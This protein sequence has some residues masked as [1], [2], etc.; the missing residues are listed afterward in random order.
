MKRVED[1][2]LVAV[3]A[4]ASACL[5]GCGD[6]RGQAQ[7][8]GDWQASA[9]AA[10]VCADSDGRRVIDEHCPAPGAQGGGGAHWVYFPR[11]AN[12]P[13]IGSPARAGATAPDGV[14]EYHPAP[15]E[16]ISRG[17]FGGTAGEGGHGEGG[18]GGGGEGGAGE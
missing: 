13:A 4:A 17:G 3:L 15:V 12:V 16:G 18:H 1:L 5:A 2:S 7:S 14:S 11:G 9:G 6:D 8:D 10:R